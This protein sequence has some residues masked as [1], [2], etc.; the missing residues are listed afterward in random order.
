MA[1]RLLN[2]LPHLIV[3]VEIEDIC[4]EVKSVLVILDIG[5]EA[6]EVEAVGKVVLVNFT[7]V[8]IATRRDELENET[9]AIIFWGKSDGESIMYPDLEAR[10]EEVQALTRDNRH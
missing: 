2:L 6:C 1:R 9:L 5:V 7:K 3:T 4:D 8:L 10:L